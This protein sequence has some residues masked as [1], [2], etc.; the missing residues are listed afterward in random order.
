MLVIENV[1]SGMV[2][3]GLGPQHPIG[4]SS[5]RQLSYNGNIPSFSVFMIL[6][7]SQLWLECHNVPPLW[8]ALLPFFPL[9]YCK[10]PL[11]TL[12]RTD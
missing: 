3:L 9:L 5:C 11:M 1:L 8:L 4:S 2:G 7:H 6:L 12:E 10:S